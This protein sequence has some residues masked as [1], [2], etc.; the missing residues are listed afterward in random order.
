[1]VSIPA[2]SSDGLKYLLTLARDG[3]D[4]P[5]S[6]FTIRVG[7]PE[8]DY[9]VLISTASQQTWVILPDG[10]KPADGLCPGLRGGTFTRNDSSTWSPLGNDLFK[11]SI[12]ENLNISQNAYFGLDTVGLGSPGSGGPTL[13]HQLLGT[14]ATEIF[15]L[16]MFGV[17][18]N[19]KRFPG[20]DEEEPSYMTS[21][22]NQ[23]IIPSLSFGYTAGAYNRE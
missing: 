3:P 15:Y 13:Q 12:E 8:K 14:I 4:G 2:R 17:N 23:G 7:T 18:P 1:M 6:S 9:R 22:K 20:I 21:L 19:P 10:C 5:W 11:L 16:G